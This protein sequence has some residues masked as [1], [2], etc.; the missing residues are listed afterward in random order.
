MEAGKIEEAK[1]TLMYL[2]R[3]GVEH[4]VYGQLVGRVEG[5]EGGIDEVRKGGGERGFEKGRRRRFTNTF[6]VSSYRP[7]GV[8]SLLSSLSRGRKTRR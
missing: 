5:G 4:K 3:K 2:K 8:F 1:E 6:L 7:F